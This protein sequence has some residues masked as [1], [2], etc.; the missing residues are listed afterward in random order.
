MKRAMIHGVS[1][2]LVY[3]RFEVVASR[4]GYPDA[5]HGTE[6]FIIDTAEDVADAI[7]QTQQRFTNDRQKVI[8]VKKARYA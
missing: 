4:V 3:K 1:Y 7:A 5:P 6:T 2:A 8:S